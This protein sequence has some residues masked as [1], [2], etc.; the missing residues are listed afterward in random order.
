MTAAD[1]DPAAD[2]VLT[3]DWG[4]RR[5]WFRFAVAHPGCHVVVA[6]DDAA[7]IV[8]TGVATIN[9]PAAWIGTIWVA[10]AFRG[11]GLG[12]A[13]TEAPIEAAEAAGCRTL[14]LVATE[15]G[16]PLYE[17]L[18]FTVQTW[19]RTF[20][21]PGLG[22]TGGDDA[23]STSRLRAFRSDDRAAMVALDRAATGEDRSALLAAL[24]G[25]DGTRVLPDADDRPA[26]YVIR[27]PWGGGATIA[28]RL[29]DGD[30]HR[31]RTTARLPD[32]PPGPLRDPPR[33]RGRRRGP[34]SR[35]LD[36]GLART[37]PRARRAARLAARAHLGPVQSR[38]GL[39]RGR[40]A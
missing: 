3:D 30:G 31:P 35:R 33:E 28:P 7:G 26:G 36:R 23:G 6:E 12:R 19:Y 20:E 18:G 40:L 17:R 38:P 15:H 16:R 4:D 34:G 8:G 25:P 29:E 21:A 5:E 22:D 39:N 9:G 24:A 2:A 27:A 10:S 14:I 37:P 13:L 1:V 11:R 32:R